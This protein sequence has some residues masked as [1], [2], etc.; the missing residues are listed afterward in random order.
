M[1]ILYCHIYIYFHRC[2]GWERGCRGCS[3][4]HPSFREFLIFLDRVSQNRAPFAVTRCSGVLHRLSW[5]LLT[6][7]WN[8]GAFPRWKQSTALKTGSKISIHVIL[9]H[10]LCPLPRGWYYVVE[11]DQRPTAPR[12][13]KQWQNRTTQL[14]PNW[15]SKSQLSQAD[16]RSNCQ[17]LPHYFMQ[18]PG[19]EL[20]L[21]RV[22]LSN[23]ST[24]IWILSHRPR[25]CINTSQPSWKV[26]CCMPMVWCALANK[27]RRMR[28]YLLPLKTSLSSLPRLVKQRYRTEMGC[29]TLARNLTT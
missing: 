3:H 10:Q 8:S 19:E 20:N 17:L 18:Y 15:S 12:S 25:T 14:M 27:F 23:Y 6:V 7:H 13:G 1:L 22:H 28:R 11:K 9:R 4:P 2:T 16:A 29:R 24:T 21:S 26:L 5:H